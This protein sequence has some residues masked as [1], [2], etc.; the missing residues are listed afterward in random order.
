MAKTK[1]PLEPGSSTGYELLL[2]PGPAGM[3]KVRSSCHWAVSRRSSVAMRTVGSFPGHAFWMNILIQEHGRY[4]QLWTRRLRL[5]LQQLFVFNS[6]KSKQKISYEVNGLVQT[7]P[8][9]KDKEGMARW[10]SG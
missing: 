10:P 7:F 2:L 8:L 3:T 1:C 5:R 4:G 6:E 9:N